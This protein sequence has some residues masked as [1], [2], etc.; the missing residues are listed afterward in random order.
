[1]LLFAM[2]ACKPNQD[3]TSP[4]KANPFEQA[5]WIAAHQEKEHFDTTYPAPFFRKEFTVREGLKS[6]QAIVTGLGYFEFYLNGQK[7][8]DQVLAPAVT[9]YDKRIKYLEFDIAPYLQQGSNVSGAVLGNG[10]Y[11]IHTASAWDFNEAPWR[12]VPVFTCKLILKYENGKTDQ[13]VSDS[14]WKWSTGPIRFEQLRNGEYYDAREELTSWARAGHDN[15]NWKKAI[16]VQGP[17]GIFSK[18]EMPQVKK[19][20]RLQPVSIEHPANG[21][22]VIDFGQN[23]AGWARIKLHEK[24]GQEIIMRYGERLYENGLLDQDELARF[25]FTG[26]TQTTRYICKGEA[27]ETYSPRFTYFGFQYL[28]IEGLSSKP[29]PDDIEAYMIH[30]AFDTLGHFKCSDPLINQIHENIQWSYLSNFHS[31]PEDC[32]HRE[33]MG[34]TGDAQLVVETG[35]FNFDVHSAYRKWLNDFS[36]EQRPSGDL[37]GI[38]PTSGW[39]YHFGK[40]L[41]TRP[42]GY[43]PQWEGAVVTIP[44]QVYRWTGDT[45]FIKSMYP[46]MKKYVAHLQDISRNYLLDIGIDDHKSIH[47]HTGGPYISS[48]YFY[49]ITGMLSKMA[50]ILNKKEDAHELDEIAKKT[51]HAFQQAYFHDKDT[52]YGNGGQTCLA[53]A[54]NCGLVPEE[55]QEKVV[56]K[57]IQEIKNRDYLF[58]AGVVGVKHLIDGLTR[59][60]REDILYKMSIQTELPSFG[61]WIKTGANTM[62]QNWDGSQSRNHIMF[63]SIGDFF[64][65]GLAGIQPDA[66]APGF[67]KIILKPFFPDDLQYLT[68]SHRSK[69]GWIKTRWKRNGGKILYEI[70][71]PKNTTATLIVRDAIPVQKENFQAKGKGHMIELA[72]GNHSF[73]LLKE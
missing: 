57:L 45:A 15:K 55:Y 22:H 17:A 73:A 21:I 36:D 1:M 63:G 10:F 14:S 26:E 38:I 68:A 65:Q 32:P 13:I 50:A 51:F 20:K 6:A 19:T 25:I 35:L 70:Q 58:D 54:L 7:V 23:I 66:S 69:Q 46:T 24:K 4:E 9:R 61:H 42:H 28:Q 11:N 49:W 71:I 52:S 39:G 62:W 2:I 8:G 18:Q 48:T 34:W 44:W 40:N 5:S 31:F 64:Y 59:H 33:K 37:P 43:G 60:G 30:T 29:D 53:L 3:K 12:N 56:S 16:E 67:K 41:E 27:G 47:T 72:P